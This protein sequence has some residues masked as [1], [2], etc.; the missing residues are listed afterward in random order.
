MQDPAAASLWGQLLTAQLQLLAADRPANG[1]DESAEE[2]EE[3][4]GEPRQPAHVQ[5]QTLPVS[6]RSATLVLLRR[7]TY[8]ANLLAQLLLLRVY[9]TRWRRGI[10]CTAC[11]FVISFAAEFDKAPGSYSCLFRRLQRSVRATAQRSETRAR[12]VAGGGGCA[13]GPGEAD[14]GAGGRAAAWAGEQACTPYS[15]ECT[16]H[17]TACSA[18]VQGGSGLGPAGRQNMAAKAQAIMSA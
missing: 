18:P 16:G 10:R 17:G 13:S 15:I 12:H 5:L 8:S 6:A 14:W 2:P 3:S 9:V 11:T 7:N 1:G 4:V